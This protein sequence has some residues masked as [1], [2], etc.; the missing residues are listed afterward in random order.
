M[1]RKLLSVLLVVALLVS[2]ISGCSKQNGK[3]K[4]S[5]DGNAPTKE[6]STDGQTG[7]DSEFSQEPV[8]LTYW[9]PLNGSASKFISSYNENTAYQEA[10]KR[11]G[12]NI[13]FI[14]PAVGQEDEQFNLMLLGDKLPDIIAYGNKYIGGEFQGMR[15]GVFLDLTDLIPEYAP[16]YNKLLQGDEEFYRE[17]TDNERKIAAFYGYKMSGDPPFTRWILNDGVLNKLNVEIPQTI[18]DFEVMFDKMLAEGITPYALAAKGYEE[19]LMGLWDIV[20]DFYIQDGQ[21]KFGQMQEGFKSYLT[22]LNEWYSKGYISKDFTSLDVNTTNTLFDSGA[23]GTFTGPI[24][25]NY[26]RGEALGIKVVPAPYPRLQP[27][28]KLHYQSANL[29]PKMTQNECTVVISKD[30]SNVEAAMKFLNYGYTQ[31][32]ADLLNWGVEG[33]NWEQNGDQKIYNDLMLNN[34][35]FGTEEAS[36]IYKMHFSPKLNYPDT[37]CHA[38][39]LK[40]EGALNVRLQWKD[41]PDMDSTLQLPPF[42]LD[43]DQQQR[44][45]EIMTQVNTYCDEMVLKF[46]TGAESLDN[47]DKYVAAIKSLGIEEALQLKQEGYDNYM[48]K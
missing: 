37:I 44:L 46:I 1:K 23:I 25:A 20:K 42:Q 2:A 21:I 32:G 28:Q 24:V 8:T 38:N 4:T 11:L 17:A 6:A 39:L 43:A 48:K 45:G 16:D 40:S 26:N 31:E 10:M 30:C 3:E 22:L 12:I 15:D 18:D 5:G 35:K 29:W 13:E 34:E 41:D 36:Y 14:H 9:V 33:L 19:Q 27:G 7:G 47:F